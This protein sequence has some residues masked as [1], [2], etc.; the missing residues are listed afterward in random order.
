MDKI[1]IEGGLPLQ[2]EVLIS[3]AKNAALPILAATLLAPGEHRLDNVPPLAD[4]RTSKRLLGNMGVQFK[5]ASPSGGPWVCPT[6][7]PSVDTSDLDRGPLRDWSRP[8]GPRSWSWGPLVARAR[9]ARVS[10]P[11]GC[12]IGARP[13]DLHLKGLEAMGVKITLN[14]GYV[15][16]DARRLHGAEIHFETAHG[17]RHRKPDDGRHSGQRHHGDQ[18]RR[19]GAGSGGPGPV[20]RGHGGRD[21]GYRHRH[22]HHPRRP[23]PAPRPPTPS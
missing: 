12:A 21:R 4:I 3:G 16:A 22:P 5:E 19:H 14:Q 7:P 17:H 2:G 10:L 13:I 18:K 1:V 23:G 9:Q 6:S 15:E 11:G 8:C 20:P